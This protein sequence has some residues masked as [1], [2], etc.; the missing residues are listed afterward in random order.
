[1]LHLDAER[2][3]AL[4]DEAID[5]IPDD[6]AAMVHNLVVLVEDQPPSSEPADTLGLYDGGT[7]G[8]DGAGYLPDRV[9]IFRR[10]LLQMCE[11]ERDLI[12]EVRITVIHEVG[13]RFGIDDDRLHEL[14][15]A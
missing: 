6:L 12:E 15:W 14:G 1:M 10:P 3:D 4:V 8:I 9:F 5:L 13:H 2:F 7:L 11:S